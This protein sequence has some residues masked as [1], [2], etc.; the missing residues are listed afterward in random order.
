MAQQ[1]KAAAPRAPADVGEAEE[2][3]GLRFA[4]LARGP[5]RGCPLSELYQPGLLGI[6]PRSGSM[7]R[8]AVSALQIQRKLRRAL[9]QILE[10]PFG[11]GTMLEAD[12]GVIGI[13]HDQ[14]FTG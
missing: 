5:V 9:P 12:D 2:V 13:P 14:H 11:I 8:Q 3:E 6:E 1:Q 7:Q 4:R 10:K